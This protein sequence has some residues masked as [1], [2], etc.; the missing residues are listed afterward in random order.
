RLPRPLRRPPAV[1]V[2][3]G[4]QPQALLRHRRLRGWGAAPLRPL[5]PATQI[6]Y[7]PDW[8]RVCVP[9]PTNRGGPRSG[10]GPRKRAVMKLHSMNGRE[11]EPARAACSGEAVDPLGRAGVPSLI[12]GASASPRYPGTPR[13]TKAFAFFAPPADARRTLGVLAAAGF[14]TELTFPH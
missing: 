7:L 12:G 14:H 13:H 10:P 9:L 1:Q 4:R 2:R 3:Q 6:A 5:P 8:H 11:R